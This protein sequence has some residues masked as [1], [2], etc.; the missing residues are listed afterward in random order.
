MVGLSA[1]VDEKISWGVSI[2][3]SL[4]GLSQ[5]SVSAEFIGISTSGLIYFLF[6]VPILFVSI[7]LCPYFLI[8]RVLG[9]LSLRDSNSKLNKNINIL[10]IFSVIFIYFISLWN[11]SSNLDIYK[12]RHL[13]LIGC[14]FSLLNIIGIDYLKNKINFSINM[15]ILFISIIFFYEVQTF[16]KI[17]LG[18]LKIFLTSLPQL[19]DSVG[20]L[21]LLF[22][23]FILFIKNKYFNKIA[24]ILSIFLIAFSVTSQLPQIIEDVHDY[25]YNLASYRV[26]F[27]DN[28]FMAEYLNS[29]NYTGKIICFYDSNFAYYYNGLT[30]RGD[31]PTIFLIKPFFDSN[32]SEFILNGMIEQDIV[33]FLVPN[34][35]NRQWYSRFNSSSIMNNT[36][37]KMIYDES[38]FKLKNSYGGFSLYIRK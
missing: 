33:G 10:F 4:W 14:L 18:G 23:F 36:I 7:V 17:N 12:T 28:N 25:N 26:N 38:F 13:I 11:I 22:G 32:N 19:I 35:T 6:A 27:G 1:A 8:P 30:I 37:I 2:S 15:F 3:N 21:I 9:I 5:G 29:N 31:L 20:I 16:L 24:I 34:E